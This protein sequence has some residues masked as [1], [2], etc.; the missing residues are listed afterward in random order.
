M[1]DRMEYQ[2]HEGDR[3]ADKAGGLSHSA[4]DSKNFFFK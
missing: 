2:S 1:Q 3:K 4:N